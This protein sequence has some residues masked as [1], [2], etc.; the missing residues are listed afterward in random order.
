M[1]VARAESLV[2]KSR[3][4]YK[5]NHVVNYA[6]TGKTDGLLAKGYLAWG[7]LADAP[8]AG[9]VVVG[10]DG[11]H[12]GIFVSAT[13]F[14]HSSSSKNQVIKVGTDQLKYVFPGGYQIRKP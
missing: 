6:L 13:H 5:C 4:T 14:V 7:S 1:S 10:T 2:G 9:Y 8:A 12:C 3:D 11:V